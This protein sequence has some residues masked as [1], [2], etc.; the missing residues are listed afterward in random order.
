MSN[1]N[2][3]GILNVPMNATQDQIKA[4]YKKLVMNFHPD[5]V[6]KEQK[7]LAE[8]QF[9]DIQRA[10]EIL[11]N[12]NSRLIYDKYGKVDSS[13]DLSIPISKEKLLREIEMRAEIEKEISRLKRFKSSGEISLGI[14]ATSFFIRKMNWLDIWDKESFP[15]IA[16]IHG[17][18]TWET[19]SSDTL[20]VGVSA[21]VMNQDGV[22]ESSLSIFTHYYGTDDVV[23]DTTGSIGVEK[24]ILFSIAK[25]Y[26]NGL[27]SLALKS[28]S[29]NLF[30]TPT[31]SFVRNLSKSYSSFLSFTPDLNN[32]GQ[33][34]SCVIGLN[35]VKDNHT[36]GFNIKA[37]NR[38]CQ[39]TLKQS[40][41]Y[42]KIRGTAQVSF[43]NM[44]AILGIGASTEINP[45]TFLGLNVDMEAGSGVAL[46][47]KLSRLGHK[48]VFPILLCDEMDI[49]FGT[50]AFC[51]PLLGFAIID[52]LVL[53]SW[54]KKAKA[55][56][57]AKIRKE[58]EEMLN[59]RK[60]EALQAIAVLSE[61]NGKRLEAE[62]KDGLIILNAIYGKLPSEALLPSNVKSK[63]LSSRIIDVSVPV[64]A[65]VHQSSLEISDQFP[66]S[67]LLGFYDP[68]YGEKKRLRISYKFKGKLHKVTVEDCDG[69]ILPKR[70]IGITNGR[71]FSHRA[72]VVIATCKHFDPFYP[73]DPK[74]IFGLPFSSLNRQSKLFTFKH[75]CL[76]FLVMPLFLPM[77]L[78]RNELQ[79]RLNLV[80][81]QSSKSRSI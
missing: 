12:E 24:S 54:R 66:K 78:L 2:L 81:I 47:L 33:L 39:V 10:F 41:Q 31:L 15:A 34:S 18:Q 79:L 13:W 73:V 80:I 21:D 63:D 56:Y 61:S 77:F 57:L 55:R 49:P 42:R 76:L 71:T 1:A 72:T 17:I 32:Q 45:A 70:G 40:V 69:L 19:Q 43:G 74:G 26:Q 6:E 68:C 60:Q 38:A 4:S 7:R 25:H 58:N 9:N 22:G 75:A 53:K 36:T 8:G 52:R 14:D 35:Y 27:L 51:V 37:A 16:N 28:A 65:L 3:Y 23:I 62:G 67:D 29:L 5:R 46:K 11:S 30:P 20:K 44:G 50:L 64:Q 48:L 59:A